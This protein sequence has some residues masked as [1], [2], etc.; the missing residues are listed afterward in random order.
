MAVVG[1]RE[2]PKAADEAEAAVG[3]EVAMLEVASVAA[4]LETEEAALGT[5]AMV[6]ATAV[7][8]EATVALGVEAHTAQS[9]Q[10]R[11]SFGQLPCSCCYRYN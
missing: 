6:V 3:R 11:V 10:Q 7:A 8:L 5:V 9:P 2:A 4:P 1:M